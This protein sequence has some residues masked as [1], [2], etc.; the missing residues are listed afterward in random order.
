M[1]QTQV[2]QLGDEGRV[3]IEII[4]TENQRQLGMGLTPTWEEAFGSIDF[5]VLFVLAI[6]GVDFFHIKRQHPVRPRFDQRGRDHRMTKMY[7][8]P[9]VSVRCKHPGHWR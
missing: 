1:M 7:L 8:S 4:A 5:T 9:L 2:A 3:T 6:A